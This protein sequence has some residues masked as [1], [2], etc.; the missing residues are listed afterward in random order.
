MTALLVRDE[1]THTYYLNGERVP[2]VTQILAPFKDFSGV[3]PDVLKRKQEIGTATHFACELDATGELDEESVHPSIAGYL[4]GFRKWRRDTGA[5]IKETESYVHH[6][7]LRYAGQLDLIAE[8]Q[9]Q[10]WLADIKTAAEHSA[11]WRLQ[12]AGYLSCRPDAA[13]L[14]RATLL[15]KPD[16]T[17]RW[18]PYDRPEHA[19]DT[20]A[21]TAQVLVH[22]W[23][24]ANLK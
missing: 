14:K 19:G 18:H 4:E 20:A 21:W 6:P 10:D 13:R 9:R 22:H 24:E 11:V 15:L 23:K 2:S 17:Y 3:P 1:A 5:K 8:L 12:T 16:G 7:R